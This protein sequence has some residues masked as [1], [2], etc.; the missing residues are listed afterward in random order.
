MLYSGLCREDKNFIVI[1]KI[2]GC[3]ELPE[4]KW[5]QFA[6]STVS[7]DPISRLYYK[8]GFHW[9]NF[10]AELNKI[11]WQDLFTELRIVT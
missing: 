11:L 7:D 9:S 2:G 6:T 5:R 4:A 3:G 10:A 8:V 1:A